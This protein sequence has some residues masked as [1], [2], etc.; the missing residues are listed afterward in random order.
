MP[1]CRDTLPLLLAEP[2]GTLDAAGLAR[3]EAH[4]ATC[5]A[6]RQQRAALA[7][8]RQVL[9][10]PVPADRVPDAALAWRE[11]RPQLRG[12]RT[13]TA[14]DGTPRRPFRWWSLTAPLATAAVFAF[15]LITTRP[16]TTPSSTQA[17]PEVAR[18]DY[19]Q[20]APDAS[21][22]VYVDQSSGWLIVWA[23][24]PS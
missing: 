16:D 8:A 19:V 5:P 2:D 14:A 24:E 1:P 17:V 20:A 4:V 22:L 12:D 11:L 10:R 6:C 13:A 3:L 7:A 23:S 18:A 21:T 15:A 9:L